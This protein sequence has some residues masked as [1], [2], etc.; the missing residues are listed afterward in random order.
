M[1]LLDA[2]D[3]LNSC[4]VKICLILIKRKAIPKAPPMIANVYKN[5]IKYVF[6]G[7]KKAKKGFNLYLRKN[8][9]KNGILKI[10]GQNECFWAI[11]QNNG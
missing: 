7:T 8:T 4:P 5:S 2:Q 1:G 3:P 11:A 9:L 10:P 6:K